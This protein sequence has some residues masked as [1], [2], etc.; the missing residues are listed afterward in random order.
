MNEMTASIALDAAAERWDFS[1]PDWAD[2]LQDGRSL[3]PSLPLD[4]R[5]GDAAVAFFDKLRVPDIE[6][7][8]RMREAAGEWFREIVRAAFGGVERIVEEAGAGGARR[9]RL[10]RMVG[11]VFILVPKKNAKTT[12]AAALGI[13]GLLMNVR[14]NVDGVIIGPTQEV[15]DKC[16]SQAAGMIEADPY[17]A[18]R[19]KVIE[20]KKT[21]L[22]LARDPETRVRRNAKLKVKSFDKKVVTGSIPFLAIVDEL[23]EMANN[24]HAKEVIL[25]IRGGMVT[26]PE[27]L[28]IFITTQSDKAPHGVFKEELALARKVRDGRFHGSRLLPVLYE[29]PEEVQRSGAWR[30]PALWPMVLPN[31]GRS[32]HLDRLRSD[33]AA[34]MEKSDESIQLWAS[35]HL[36]IQIG[37][38]LHEDRWRG[39]DD[40]EGAAEPGITFESLLARSEVVTFGFDAGGSGDLFGVAVM[41]RERETGRILLWNEALCTERAMTI[42]PENAAQLAD[43]KALGQLRVFPD[44]EAARL[45][46]HAAAL[47][48]RAWEE[49]LMPAVQAVGVDT[50]QQA[51]LFGAFREAGLPTDL[52]AIVHQG[53]KLSAAIWWVEKQ[54]LAGAFA[55]AGLTLMDWAVSNAKAEEVGKNVYIVKKSAAAKIDPLVA[56]FNAGAIMERNPEAAGGMLSPWDRDPNF[57][58]SA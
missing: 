15:S 47:V 9:E 6:G 58:L 55:H 46:A 27:S 22:D 41:G 32:I 23:H 51:A 28:L 17:L 38:G 10:V 1:C 2:R 45:P 29:F 56:T 21:I 52:L 54:L 31:L 37:L 30:A 36:N 26:N 24:R 44:A 11:E 18:R 19:F 14:P 33:Y 57:R 13:V 5:E 40:W 53:W 34:A 50:H 20:H 48:K 43:L 39:A 25:Q 49:G 7:Q 35:Q 12:Y 42:R 4:A 8:P 16:F 3:M